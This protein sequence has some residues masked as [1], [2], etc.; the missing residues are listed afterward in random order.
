MEELHPE[1]A[2]P[3][4]L[5]CG[6][7][8]IR[9]ATEANDLAYLKR[10]A[11]IYARRFPEI[12]SASPED[13]LCDGCLSDR[14][15]LF[16]QEC[17]IRDCAQQKGLEGCHACDEFPCAFIDEFPMPA[18]QKVIL[19]SVPYRREHGT[20]RWARAE[21]ERYNCPECGQRLF[22]G[23]KQCEGCRTVVDLD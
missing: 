16:C 22:R 19:R 18:G 10:L 13:L 2:S 20:E 3:C 9:N 6:V 4:G 12:A 23:A 5:Y 11:R 7:C 17:S 8:R 21:E 14:R 1:Y 15:W